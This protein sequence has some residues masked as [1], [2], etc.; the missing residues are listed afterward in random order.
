M[1]IFT[2]TQQTRTRVL[3]NTYLIR[4][5]FCTRFGILLS[6]AAGMP[7]EN[8]LQRPN[9]SW[10]LEGC[11]ICKFVKRQFCHKIGRTVILYFVLLYYIHGQGIYRME[12]VGQ[13]FDSECN[14]VACKLSVCAKPESLFCNILSQFHSSRERRISIKHN[15][16]FCRKDYTD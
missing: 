4:N 8:D 16:L 13:L 11:I 9:C 3:Y 10:M 7:V 6:L 1:Y 12:K 14:A 5:L 15:L 2:G